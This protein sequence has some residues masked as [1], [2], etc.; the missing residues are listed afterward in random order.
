MLPRW[1]NKLLLRSEK[2]Q[3]IFLN[4][5][6][7]LYFKQSKECI[8]FTIL[9]CSFC[10]SVNSFWAKKIDLK[11]LYK[12]KIVNWV[13]CYL[14]SKKSFLDCLYSI[15]MRFLYENRWTNFKR[16]Q[17]SLK[18]T[19]NWALCLEYFLILII[20]CQYYKFHLLLHFKIIIR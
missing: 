16:F 11:V 19:F 13:K 18:H 7:I 15:N 3:T 20:I 4:K 5:S 10:F 17:Y 6:F 8:V 9:M 12:L 1:G 14:W 2:R